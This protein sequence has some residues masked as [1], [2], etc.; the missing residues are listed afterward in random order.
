MNSSKQRIATLAEDIE[1]LRD[2]IEALAASVE[3]IEECLEDGA[4]GIY[5]PAPSWADV[6]VDIDSDAIIEITGAALDIAD[7]ASIGR[8]PKGEAE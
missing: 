7:H 2:G 3:D 1:R 5:G 6:S 4:S 8:A